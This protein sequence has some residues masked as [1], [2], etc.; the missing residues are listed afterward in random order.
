MPQENLSIGILNNPQ[1]ELVPSP[2]QPNFSR[3][4]LLPETRNFAN[5]RVF[6]APPRPP[7]VMPQPR[8]N[9]FP[10]ANLQVAASRPFFLPPQ[11]MPSSGGIGIGATNM[12]YQGRMDVSPIDGTKPYIDLLDKPID[13]NMVNNLA[14]I[15]DDTLNLDLR[16]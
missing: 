14:N 4:A 12:A 6:Q 7:V 5:S 16:L 11:V 1:R 10:Y 15:N 2:L 3:P 13:N 9:P 8:T